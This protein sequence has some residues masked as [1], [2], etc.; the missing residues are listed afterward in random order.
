MYDYEEHINYDEPVNR[1]DPLTWVTATGCV[2][3]VAELE[4]QHL[5]NIIRMLLLHAKLEMRQRQL[6]YVF[7]PQPHGEMAQDAFDHEFD[8][9]C[10]DGSYEV[11][12]SPLESILLEKVPQWKALVER[13]NELGIYDAVLGS[14]AGRP[15]DWLG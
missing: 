4:A 10:G 5:T 13:C 1:D 3:P 7:G 15:L 8:Y 12:E 2:I 14:K 11:Q 6:F 9:W